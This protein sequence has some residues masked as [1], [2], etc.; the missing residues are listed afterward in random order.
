MSGVTAAGHVAQEVI[1]E[2]A[3]ERGVDGIPHGS[4][5]QHMPI[6]GRTHHRLGRDVAAGARPVLD[7]KLLTESL[8]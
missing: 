5:Q 8:G 7:D 4:E 6:G 2:I 1:I 3:I